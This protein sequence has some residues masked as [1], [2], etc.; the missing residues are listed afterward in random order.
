MIGQELNEEV[1]N[2]F[3]IGNLKI[4]K[5]NIFEHEHSIGLP[6]NPRSVPR[7][8]VFQDV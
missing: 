8:D 7:V 2:F 6:W 3:S 4:I 5:F 1:W